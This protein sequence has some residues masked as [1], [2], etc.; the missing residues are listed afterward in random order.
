[1]GFRAS[2]GRLRV[3]AAALTSRLRTR[4][5]RTL[6]AKLQG[7]EEEM[8]GLAVLAVNKA[9]ATHRARP[10]RLRNQ[11]KY[12]NNRPAGGVRV[13]PPRVAARRGT[14]VTSL[15]EEGCYVVVVAPRD[16]ASAS[17]G[18]TLEEKFFPALGKVASAVFMN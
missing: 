2:V 1:M 3:T 5:A 7:H 8:D 11:A 18:E 14:G 16:R 15:K 13:A 10:Q 17:L 4:C 6:Q 9:E 12:L